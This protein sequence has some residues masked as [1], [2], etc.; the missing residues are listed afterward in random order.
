MSDI[1]EKI[2]KILIKNNFSEETLK[3]WF[4]PLNIEKDEKKIY[5]IFQH[6]F[7]FDN[8]KI[9]FKDIIENDINLDF[10]YKILPLN[11]NNKIIK[12]FKKK[13]KENNRTLNYDFTF[14]NFI[15]NK[16]NIFPIVSAKEICNHNFAKFNP[17][18]IYGESSTGKTHLLKAIVNEILKNKHNSKILF[19]NSD[20][21]NN[22]Y[23]VN[24]KRNHITFKQ[25]ID[26]FDYLIIDDFQEVLNFDSLQK[27]LVTIF[28]LFYE[29]KKQMIFS[30]TGK[31]LLLDRLDKKLKSR[32]EWGLIVNLKKPDLEI[33]TKFIRKFCEDKKIKLSNEQILILAQKFKNLRN[34]KGILLKILAYTQLINNNLREKDFFSILNTVQEKR[35]DNLTFENI[36]DIVA[37]EM[38][39]ERDDILSSK[40]EK[41]IVKARQVSMFLCRKL[42]K[43]SYPEIG[44]FF[45]GKD[46]STVIYSVKKI[47]RLKEDSRFM[48]S[49]LKNLEQ[50]C[51]SQEK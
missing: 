17:F 39:L 42:L 18:V 44:K 3:I 25:Y 24:F 33:R 4:D 34:I 26:N 38:N 15:Y 28:D 32:L 10:E 1:K 23:I 6:R 11:T 29:Q 19:I 49:L 5:I 51:S 48:K 31:Y 40:R 20:D 46:H 30:Y 22:K 2:K 36:I 8:Y 16:K 12:N 43:Y 35:A 9:K 27:E 45:G 7:L 13:N 47:Q 14:K 21:L 41:K 50:K 37:E